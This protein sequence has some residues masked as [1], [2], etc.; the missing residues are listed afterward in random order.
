MILISHRGNIN[1]KNPDLENSIPY[2]NNALSK[3]FHIEVDVWHKNNTFTLVM[4]F[5]NMR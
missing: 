4:I 5:L 2:L 1:S 3:G